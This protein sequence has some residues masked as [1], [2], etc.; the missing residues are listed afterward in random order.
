MAAFLCSYTFSAQDF[1]AN[2]DKLVDLVRKLEPREQTPPPDWAQRTDTPL[3][4]IAWVSD[5]HIVYPPSVEVNRE[6]LTQI[7]EKTHPVAVIISGDSCGMGNSPRERQENLRDFLKESLGDDIGTIVVPGD[8]W[9]QGFD[10]VF[11]ANKFAFTLGGFRFICASSDASGIKNGCSIF[12]P[13]T[14]EWLKKQL[15]SSGNSPVIYVQH[16]PVEP[17]GTLSAAEIAAIFDKTPNVRLALGGHI[18]LDLAF[19]RAHWK[20]WLCPTTMQRPNASTTFKLLSFYRDAIICQNWEKE[21]GAECT[22]FRPVN[23][24]LIARIP[25][26]FQAGLHKVEKFSMDDYQA[27]PPRACVSDPKLDERLNELTQQLLKFTL[28]FA[29]QQKR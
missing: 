16:E 14:M 25:E 12:Y 23:K 8:N 20:Q 9:P 6:I 13:D 28:K 27:M 26:V 3:F 4:Q 11:G 5:M 18:H 29:L 22:N 1:G 7:R 19:S 15:A 2:N 17:P 24:F 10:E 21:T